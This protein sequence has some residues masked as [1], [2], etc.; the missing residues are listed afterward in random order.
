[1]WDAVERAVAWASTE[2]GGAFPPRG[3][4]TVIDRSKERG[5]IRAEENVGPFNATRAYV[6]IFVS[7]PRAGAD[8][9]T[10]EVSKI[11]KARSEVIEGRNWEADL[12][13]AIETN[14]RAG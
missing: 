8:V 12:L 6:G 14:L 4:L 1:V 5:L 11:L 7:P 2:P 13:R 3:P 9:Y 10:V